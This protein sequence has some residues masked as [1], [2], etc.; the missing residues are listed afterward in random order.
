M[1]HEA[2]RTPDTWVVLRITVDGETIHKLYAGWSESYLYGAS[3]RLNSGIERVED[4]G[5]AWLVHGAS[6]SVYECAKPMER[7]NGYQAQVLAA[8]EKQLAEGDSVEI[9]PIQEVLP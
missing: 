9:V 8:M 6:G 3:W 7:M 1:S 4:G 2:A 5:D